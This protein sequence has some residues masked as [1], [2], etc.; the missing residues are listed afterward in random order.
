MEQRYS[1]EA[2][3]SSVSQ[4]I[5]HILWNLNVR[6]RID[7]N[8]PPAPIVIQS[9]PASHFLKIHFNIILPSTRNSLRCVFWKI[10]KTFRDNGFIWTT[11]LANLFVR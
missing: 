8:F 4:E 2:N 5:P 3:G 7:T 6:R 1:W 10:N 11:T 9:L